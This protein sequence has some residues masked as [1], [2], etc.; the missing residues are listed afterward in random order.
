MNGNE[1]SLKDRFLEAV[2]SGKLGTTKEFGVVVTVQE[3]K[4]YFKDIES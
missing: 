4:G 3:F 1:A 2:N